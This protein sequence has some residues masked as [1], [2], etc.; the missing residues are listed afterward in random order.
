MTTTAYLSVHNVSRVRAKNYHPNNGNAI[1]LRIMQADGSQFE[2]NIFDLPED[3]A[4]E[5]IKA[6]GDAETTVYASGGYQNLTDY[7]TTK[8]VF[9]AIEGK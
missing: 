8:G 1:E 4:I 3:R 9:D 6:L 7:L 5:M 2:L